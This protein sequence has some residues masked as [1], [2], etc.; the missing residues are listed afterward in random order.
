MVYYRTC[1]SSASA[2][3]TAWA[4]AAVVAVVPSVQAQTETP[5]TL[6]YLEQVRHQTGAP[7]VTAAVSVDGVIVF[8]DGVGYAELDNQTPATGA[9][10]LNVGSV[11]KVMAVIAIMQLV[12]QGKVT[13][14]DDI[15]AYVTAF[16]DKG[17]PV[18]L[19]QIMTH[20]SGIRDYRDGEFGPNGLRS[21]RHFDDFEEAIQHFT[22]DP[23]LFAPG[24]YWLYSSH[25]FN[26]LQGVV[27]K[28]SGVRFE[29]YMQTYVWEPAGMLRSSFDVPSRVVR[30]RGRGYVRANDGTIVNSRYEDVSYKYAGGG[31]LSTVEDLVRMGNAINNGTLLG[32]DAVTEMHTSRVDPVLQF[33]AN[34]QPRELSFKQALG[35]D[36]S[37]DGQGRTYISKT[38]TVRG[39]RYPDDGLVVALQANIAPFPIQRH[40]EAIAQIYLPP[41][42]AW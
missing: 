36:L 41:V 25:A 26:L 3:R 39:T 8:S 29:N 32:P 33:Q 6:S 2:M 5:S 22:E 18:T 27:E 38:G 34:G 35:W 12:E 31:M 20:T 15:R 1:R 4:L 14:S 40:G 11:S 30:Q 9:T 10:V 16:P 21:M 23:L 13:L 37:T 17:V 42:R 19:R 24:E 7:G 28:V